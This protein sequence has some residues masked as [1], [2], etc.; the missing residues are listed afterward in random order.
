MLFR[1]RQ[2]EVRFPRPAL[3]MGIINLTPDSFSDGGNLL[4]PRAA[5]GR[6]LKLVAAGAE[7]LDIGGESTRPGAKPVAEKEELRRVIPVFEQLAAKLGRRPAKPV[8]L[9][10]DTMKPAVARAALAAGA[11]MVNDVAANRRDPAM[12]RVIAEFG[13][14]YI[15]MHAQGSPLTMQRNPAYQDVI[16][17]VR[18][19]FVERLKKLR[20]AGIAPEQVIFDP[21]IGFGK[22][23]EHNLQLLAHLNAF[24]GLKRPLLLGVSRKSFIE[25]ISG[26]K[27]NERLPASLACATLA[28]ESGLHL[29]RTHD[30]AETV[31]ALRMAEAILSR[32]INVE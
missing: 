23:L 5:V 30:V 8:L 15:C 17:E 7:I 24:A 31:Q 26:A 4:S 25:K 18:A 21:G 13:A 6:A 27:L 22:T 29:V 10:I 12:W 9:S 2:F 32:K 3:V 19:F 16:R 1:A 28:L 20:A 11:S 14:G